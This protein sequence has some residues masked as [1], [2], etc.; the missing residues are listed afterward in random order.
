MAKPSLHIAIIGGG[1]GGLAAAIGIKRAGHNVTL[2]EQASQF[3]H[4]SHV[5]ITCSACLPLSLGLPLSTRRT[6]SASIVLS[7]LEP[8]V[9]KAF[10][11]GAGIQIPP[12]SARILHAWGLIPEI[13]KY[14]VQPSELRFRA[15]KDGKFL[16]RINLSN[17]KDEYGE[18]FYY[19]HRADFHTVV[20]DEARRLGVDIQLGATVTKIDFEHARIEVL[21]REEPMEADVIIGADGLNSVTR[22]LLLGRKDPPHRTGD[23][24]YRLTVKEADMRAHPILH[25]LLD[26]NPSDL[27]IG[28][29]TFLVGYPLKKNGYYNI[30]LICPDTMPENIDVAKATPQEM[31]DLLEGWDPKLHVVL[32]LIEQPQKWRMFTSREMAEWRHPAGRF[33]MLGDA[34]HASLPYL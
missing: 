17:S 32:D 33:A 20:A 24:A 25:E 12:N 2:L 9:L 16:H 10:Q 1:L 26:D 3:H 31:R 30:A 11:V 27:W 4:V 8:P 34:C 29:D 19:I 5:F 23:M 22:E 14:S 7:W 18:D 28:P 21:G 15:W 6:R 13:V